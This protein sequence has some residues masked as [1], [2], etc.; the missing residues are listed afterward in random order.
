MNRLAITALIAAALAAPTELAAQ[1]SNQKQGRGPAR[2]SKQF[3]PP[4]GMC[5]IWINGVPANKQPAPTDCVTALRN[6]PSNGRILFGDVAKIIGSGLG[7]RGRTDRDDD[8]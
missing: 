5:R 7:R 1:R 6:R 3:Q 2:V 4:P 8:R